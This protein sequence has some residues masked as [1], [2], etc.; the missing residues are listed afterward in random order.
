MSLFN[1][2]NNYDDGERPFQLT[3]YLKNSDDPLWICNRQDS[4]VEIADQLMGDSEYDGGDGTVSIVG[5][6]LDPHPVPITLLIKPWAVA[7]VEFHPITL[8][9]CKEM[10]DRSRKQGKM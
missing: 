4:I 2:K 6:K 7:A 8:Q 3:I 10:S 9:R 5:V 1:Q